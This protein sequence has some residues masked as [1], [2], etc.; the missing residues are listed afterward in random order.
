M[1]LGTRENFH[2]RHLT[3]IFSVVIDRFGVDAEE[4]GGAFRVLGNAVETVIKNTDGVLSGVVR[5]EMAMLDPL[6]KI[7][8][9]G[10]RSKSLL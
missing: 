10:E 3:L 9:V 2:N 8:F 1:K 4:L 6:D 7:I 5:E